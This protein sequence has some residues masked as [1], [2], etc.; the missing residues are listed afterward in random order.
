VALSLGEDRGQ[1]SY[2]FGC[3]SRGGDRARRLRF[4]DGDGVN[5]AAATAAADL[6][7]GA[8]AGAL[9]GAGPDAEAARFEEEAGPSR[10]P[11]RNEE[12]DH[13]ND[14]GPGPEPVDRRLG[15]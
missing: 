13:H 4:E 9:C 3:I 2:P 8:A 1:E 12:N 5:R 7:P 10:A 11:S 14:D 15:V 6:C